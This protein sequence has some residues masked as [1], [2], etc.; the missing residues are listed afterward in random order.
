M[1]HANSNCLVI[2]S[3]FLSGDAYTIFSIKICTCSL[4]LHNNE[5]DGVSN[6]QRY[7][8]LLNRLFRHRSKKILKFHVTVFCE[9]N[10][11]VTGEFPTQMASNAE[12]VSISWRHH[13]IC[14]FDWHHPHLSVIILGMGSAN[15]RWHYIVMSSLIGWAHT[16]NDPWLIDW[17]MALELIWGQ[18]S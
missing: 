4:Q 17:P 7:N 16:Q 11:P 2:G 9:G 14:L 12:K 10:S 8:C 5:R 13:V 1:R 3:F 15:E 18:F 6:H